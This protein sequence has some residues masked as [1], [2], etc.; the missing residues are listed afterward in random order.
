MKAMRALPRE[1][2]VKTVAMIESK[3]L[4]KIELHDFFADLKAYEFEMN[5]RKEEEEPSTSTSTRALVTADEKSAQAVVKTTDQLCDDA[6]VLFVKKF[7]RF[8]KTNHSN[9]SH[10]N[11]N[12]HENDSSSN[13]KCFN[14]DRPG[15]F[16]ADCKKP[17][18]DDRK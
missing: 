15:H 11:R 12:N 1:W 16:A 5:S 17:R 3:D 14:C 13:L 18:R 10:F 6:I 9:S 7:G 2:E 8:M 4:N